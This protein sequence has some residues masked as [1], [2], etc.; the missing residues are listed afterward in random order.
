V[1]GSNTKNLPAYP[2]LSQA[3]KNAMSFILSLM[4]SLQQNWRRGQNRFCLEASGVGSGE[5]VKRQQGEIAQTM[6]T[7]RIKCINKFKKNCFHAF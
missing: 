4:F 2:S 5:G 1:H 3:R 6:Y 7:H